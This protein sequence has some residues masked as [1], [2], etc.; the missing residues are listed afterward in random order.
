MSILEEIIAA[1]KPSVAPKQG[2]PIP[3]KELF[4]SWMGVARKRVRKQVQ[5]ELGHLLPEA[6][7]Q[8]EESLV[9]RWARCATPSL[10]LELSISRM[11][12]DLHGETAED[13]YVSFLQA[14]I[15]DHE[16]LRA[17]F[18]EYEELGRMLACLLELWVT[19]TVEFLQRLAQDLPLLAKTF[20][21]EKTLGKVSFLSQ[22]AGDFHEGGRSVYHLKFESGNE[23]F[24]KPKNLA[25]GV[26]FQEF[27]QE[28]NTLGLP[29]DLKGYKTVARGAY[30]WEE[31]VR[32]LPCETPDQVKRY[33]QRTGMLL[34]LLY[35]F[36][37]TD[38]HHENLI[39]SGEYPILID[40]ETF[41]HSS[42]A[43]PDK[44]LT[45]D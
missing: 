45:T 19:Q 34:A 27:M 20:N 23:I 1:T 41:F 37:G 31:M 35:L 11:Q 2:E 25:F 10:A 42:L 29:L 43:H 9:L 7:H 36:D 3:F 14:R 38:I 40:L 44:E 21:E 12:D 22:N 5:R 39:A 13:R 8:M 33:F 24:Y 4:W 15:W 16:R 26:Q 17:F 30:G 32:H 6:I 28:I 18:E